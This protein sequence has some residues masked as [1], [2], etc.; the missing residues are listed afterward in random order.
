MLLAAAALISLAMVPN[1]PVATH[2][3]ELG[4]LVSSWL[5]NKPRIM[6]TL[7]IHTPSVKADACFVAVHRMPSA[8]APT[9]NGLS[10][11][12]YAGTVTPGSA[13]AVRALLPAAP[14]AVDVKNGYHILYYEPQ[15]FFVLVACVSGHRI[16]YSWG[17]FIQVVPHSMITVKD[18]Y[19]PSKPPRMIPVA[20]ASAAT[21]PPITP[22]GIIDAGQLFKCNIH[23]TDDEGDSAT[24]Y[25]YTWVEGPNLYSMNGLTTRMGLKYGSA[26]YFESFYAAENCDLGLCGE[27]PPGWTSAGKHLASSVVE[28]ETEPLTGNHYVRILFYVEYRYEMWTMYDSGL[29]GTGMRYW[30]LYPDTITA[31]MRADRLGLPWMGDYTPPPAPPYAMPGQSHMTIYFAEPGQVILSDNVG[32]SVGVTFGV[33]GA[34]SVTLKVHLYHAVR[35]SEGFTTPY[36]RVDASTPYTWWYKCNDK[37]TMEAMFGR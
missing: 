10:K 4:L 15:E 2:T 6:V 9:G 13:V 29:T 18:I 25:C 24:G 7:V 21:R 12:I 30:M 11:R 17:R 20:R 31:V 26:A 8:S 32:A 37:T 33:P 3:A 36:V 34:W 1:T 28:E 19:P 16:V 14:G 27:T 5:H 22:T 23:V 35:R